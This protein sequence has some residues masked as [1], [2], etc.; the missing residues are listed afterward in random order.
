MK[1][2]IVTP[3]Y[4]DSKNLEITLGAV[5]RLTGLSVEVIVVDGGSTDD[6]VDVARRYSGLVS[7]I[8]SGPDS[9]IYDAMNKGLALASGEY[10]WFINAGD[11][12]AAPDTAKILLEA[13]SA[14]LHWGDAILIDEAR[15]AVGLSRGPRRLTPQDFVIGMSVCHQSVIVRR[16]VCPDYDARLRYVADQK[17]LRGLAGTGLKMRRHHRPL[18]RYLLGG[19][20]E[21]QLPAVLSEK[22][23]FSFRE[24]SLL[25]AIRATWAD[26]L[27][28][29]RWNARRAVM[30]LRAAK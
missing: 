15:R 25:D 20:S 22:I 3:V 17:W 1:L 2:S 8:H 10:V 13:P 18:A 29:V 30:S 14:D 28:L 4:N 16:S 26:G 19:V 12:P 7:H 24:M 23:G 27:K 11:E 9:G 6:S 5:S 21:S